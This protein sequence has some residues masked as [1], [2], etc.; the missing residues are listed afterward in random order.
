M[1]QIFPERNHPRMKRYPLS[2]SNIRPHCAT[3]SALDITDIAPA[4]RRTTTPPCTSHMRMSRLCRSANSPMFGHHTPLFYLEE[5]CP[6]ERALLEVPR[7]IIFAI[8]HS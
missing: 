8:L 4:F 5:R 6:T 3:P 2:Y 7:Q 1:F